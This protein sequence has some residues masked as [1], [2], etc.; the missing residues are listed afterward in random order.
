MAWLRWLGV[1]G[2]I[3]ELERKVEDLELDLGD[4]RDR[5]KRFQNRMN[6]R[7]ARE[8]A[9]EAAL[10][11]LATPRGRKPPDGPQYKGGIGSES[12]GEVW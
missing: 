2:D 9:A 6:M 5:F 7:E 3:S 4:L 1:R 8:L 12:Q 10:T 11:A